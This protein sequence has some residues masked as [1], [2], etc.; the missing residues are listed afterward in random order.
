MENVFTNS[1]SQIQN[2][3]KIIC[4]QT[5]NNCKRFSEVLLYSIL[6][7][8]RTQPLKCRYRPLTH[9]SSPAPVLPSDGTVLE[10]SRVAAGFPRDSQSEMVRV[11]IQYTPPLLPHLVTVIDL[12]S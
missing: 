3:S 10:S 12:S 7:L 6:R 5:A 1:H 11:G 4:G 8:S 2:A 9:Q